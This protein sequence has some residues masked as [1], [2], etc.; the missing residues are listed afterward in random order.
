MTERKRTISFA[1]NAPPQQQVAQCTPFEQNINMRRK[2]CLKK[3]Y[4]ALNHSKTVNALTLKERL[5]SMPVM[6]TVINAAADAN[7]KTIVP[8]SV[9]SSTSKLPLLAQKR[10]PK[11]LIHI[12]KKLRKN[13]CHDNPRMLQ[14]TLG[15]LRRSIVLSSL[16]K[17]PTS[18]KDCST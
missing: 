12:A 15:T 8:L 3:S 1:N 4:V 18:D 10:W 13:S 17:V 16:A 2:S 5:C 7:T 11:N 6:P 14:E 9:A